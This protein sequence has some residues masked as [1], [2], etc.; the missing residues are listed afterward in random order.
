MSRARVGVNL[1]WLVPGRV[2]GS[3]EATVA[4]LLAGARELDR[5]GIDLVMLC[6]PQVSS[7][8]PLL[9]EHF[10]IVHV[11]EDGSNKF[12][13]VANEN[14]LLGR[15]CRQHR[16]DLIHHGGGVVPLGVRTPCSLTIHDL[17]PLDQPHNFDL[18]KLA[19]L[20]TVLAPS[21]R[22]ARIVMCPSEYSRLRV[23]EHLGIASQRVRVVPWVAL[24]MQDVDPKSISD[25]RERWGLRNDFI[26]YPAVTHP[27]KNHR[28]LIQAFEQMQ[29]DRPVDLVLTGGAGSSEG[30]VTESIHTSALRDR[31][32]RLGRIDRRDL[33]ALIASA[34]VV[35]FPSSYEGFGLPV[36]EAMS[37]GTAVVASNVGSLPEVAG[38]LLSS[39]EP[40][41]VESWS[42][43]LTTVLMD[44]VERLSRIAEG[45][46]RAGLFTPERS[47]GG[48][49]QAIHDA[50][51]LSS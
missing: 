4:T 13:R 37:R 5:F 39:L 49:A 15:L 31:I 43:T 47:G 22:R 10:E 2:G 21:A 46:Q 16:I 40:A 41:D 1:L 26:L 3:E 8:Y 34:T 24:P 35:A 50:L 12:R 29:V 30:E 19:Y 51:V 20:K 7:A 11:N 36:L 17:Q 6:S 38:D 45:S 44:P 33:D 27:H 48:F 14:I 32:H 18:V 9:G 42:S 23:V 25:V 28:V